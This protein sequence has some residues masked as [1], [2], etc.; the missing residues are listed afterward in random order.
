ML[1]PG[2][3]KLATTPLPSGSPAAAITIGIVLVACFAAIAG[4]VPWV[5]TY[6]IGY[7]AQA[8]LPL[9]IGYLQDG[10]RKFGYIVEGQNLKIEYRFLQDTLDCCW[11]RDRVEHSIAAAPSRLMKS[12]RLIRVQ[13]THIHG[14]D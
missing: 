7:L 10:L 1:P 5:T 12:R 3:A 11:A 4:G 13:K 6:T 8:R 14:I 2:C 9:V